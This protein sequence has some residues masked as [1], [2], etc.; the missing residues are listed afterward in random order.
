[1][2]QICP[3][4]GHDAA[5]KRALVLAFLFAC[6]SDHNKPA[7]ASFMDADPFMD[8]PVDAPVLP[9]FRTPHPEMSDDQV[10]NRA[11]QLIGLQSLQGATEQSCNICHAITKPKL[12]TWQGLSDAA[13]HDCLTDLQV[14][15]TDS[16]KQMMTCIRLQPTVETSMFS[17]T[18]LGVYATAAR[19]PWFDYTIWKAYGA[20]APTQKASFLMT[21]AMPHGSDV[22]PL[23]QDQFDIVSEWFARG[24]PLLDQYIPDG[25]PTSC[26]P[27]ITSLVAAHTTDMA[28]TG[29]RAVNR[30]NSL[31]MFDCGAATDPKLCL[32]NQPLASTMAYGTGWDLP[33]RGTSRVLDEITFSSS[34]WTRSSADGRFVG[35]GANIGHSVI[36]DL[37]RTGG[38]FHIAISASYDPG[39]FPDNSGWV[40]QNGTR[41]TCPQSLLTSNPSSVSMTEAGCTDINSIGLY[42]HVGRALN[43]GDY[44]TINGLFTSD[45]GGHSLT[46]HQPQAPFGTTSSAHFTPLIYTGTAYQARPAVTVT[47]AY[48][49][50]DVI[51]P[52]ATLEITRLG[53]ANTGVQLGYV[54][55]K[56]NITGTAPTYSITTPEIARYCITGGK[57]AFS[58][59]ERWIV[60]HHYVQN[61]TADAIDLGFTATTDA[62]FQAY[63]TQGAANIYLMD[64]ATG[65]PVRITNMKPGQYALMPH[66]RSDGWIYAN[67]RDT[68]NG[69]E[70][71]IAHDAALQLE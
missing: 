15:T 21:A 34:Y 49:G 40:F 27:D 47:Q 12:R 4:I 13:M 2:S 68:T 31:A 41:N 23:T 16:A 9:A 61:T 22:V 53:N 10:A 33:S 43:G 55:H 69:H 58:Y 37:A 48:E 5:V 42:Q 3:G 14:Q 36:T 66:F 65:T 56:V 17:P 63:I 62:G 50:D 1:M 24:L 26:T 59:D 30:D 11:L 18:K 52:S 25:P 39:F 70:Y 57:P 8:A 51:S 7:D 20:D 45:N 44:F 71:F 67:V 32:Q 35:Y 29:W 64:L 46:N 38:P 60:Y 19:L 28:T 54:L 6:G